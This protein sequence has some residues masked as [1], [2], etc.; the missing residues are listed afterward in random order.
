MSTLPATLITT[1][2]LVAEYARTVRAA[3]D[4]L[5]ADTLDDLTDGLEADLLDALADTEAGPVDAAQSLEDVTT[6]FGPARVYADELRAAA[7]LAPRAE[8]QGA[9]ARGGLRT[10]WRQLRTS[11][12]SQLHR[13]QGSATWGPTLSFFVALRPVWWVLRAWVIVSAL[14]GFQGLFPDG[15][16]PDFLM[17]GAIVVSVQWGRGR[18]RPRGLRWAPPVAGVL[19]VLLLQPAVASL[20]YP[21]E[22]VASS[23]QPAQW[24]APGLSGVYVDGREAANLYVYDAQGD[25]VPEAQVFDDQ[26]SPVMVVTPDGDDD[27]RPQVEIGDDEQAWELDPASATGGRLLW[28]VYPLHGAPLVWDDTQG[29]VRSRQQVPPLPFDR[30]PNTVAGPVDQAAPS[31]SSEPTVDGHAAD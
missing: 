13:L 26:G 27:E 17:L 19:A 23:A 6:Q 21:S 10:A 31:N 4:D 3:L 18:W 5:P 14:T 16:P 2:D 30:A 12:T 25:P 11:A 7:G 1:R 9:S 8:A 28:N 24:D 29:L 20:V 15:L 22:A